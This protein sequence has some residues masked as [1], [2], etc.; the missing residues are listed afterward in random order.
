VDWFGL[1]EDK[2]ELLPKDDQGVI[3]SRVFPGLWLNTK[4]LMEADSASLI[5]S[6]EA[7]LKAETVTK[8]VRGQE[9]VVFRQG[10]TA[11]AEPAVSG[12]AMSLAEIFEE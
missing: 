4:A 5:A 9:P 11:D 1:Q 12:W 3:R 2:Y 6:L 8:Y 10:D 7:G